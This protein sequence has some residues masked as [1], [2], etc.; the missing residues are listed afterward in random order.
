MR[1]KTPTFPHIQ[2]LPHMTR[3]RLLADLLA[4]LGGIDFVLSDLDR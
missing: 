1:I 3:G 4:V 2:A